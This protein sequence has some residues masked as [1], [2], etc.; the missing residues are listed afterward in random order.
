MIAPHDPAGANA[1]VC[2]PAKENG[3]PVKIRPG[4]QQRKA[5]A[6]KK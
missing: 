1:E 4:H 5:A 3:V 2:P 6:R